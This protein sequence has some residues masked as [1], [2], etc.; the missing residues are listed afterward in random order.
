M[1]SI[2]GAVLLCTQGLDRATNCSYSFH[3]NLKVIP[4]KCFH[5]YVPFFHSWFTRWLALPRYVDECWEWHGCSVVQ[6]DALFFMRRLLLSLITTSLECGEKLLCLGTEPE[7]FEVLLFGFLP[8]LTFKLKVCSLNQFL[9]LFTMSFAL[10]VHCKLARIRRF[11]SSWACSNDFRGG[12]NH[13][14]KRHGTTDSLY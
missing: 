5:S 9:D 13:S 7:V 8:E 6:K 14:S 12:Y 1:V 11:F 4:L 10:T 3:C 2:K